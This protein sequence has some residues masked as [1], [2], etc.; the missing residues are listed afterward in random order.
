MEKVSMRHS[1]PYVTVFCSEFKL[2]VC[3]RLGKI[4]LKL[5]GHQLLKRPICLKAL[6]SSSLLLLQLQRR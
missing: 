1:L 5:L 4:G 2:T 3:S 6:N